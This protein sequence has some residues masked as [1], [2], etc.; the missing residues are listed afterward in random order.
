[1]N[2]SFA[3]LHDFGISLLH[4]P[5]LA[6]N[7]GW[8]LLRSCFRLGLQIFGLHC[9]NCLRDGVNVL[10]RRLS[11]CVG[12]FSIHFL[13]S[14]RQPLQLI[15]REDFTANQPEIKSELRAAKYQYFFVKRLRDSSSAGGAGAGA[16]ACAG[17]AWGAAAWVGCGA[18]AGSAFGCAGAA[19]C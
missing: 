2:K 6:A 15:A 12:S 3:H 11:G 17:A 4:L 1:M 5:L 13:T 16:G 18:G 9:F 8:Q 10:P 7:K 19:V 14:N